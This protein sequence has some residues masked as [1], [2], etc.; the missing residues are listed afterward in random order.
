MSRYADQQQVTNVKTGKVERV[1]VNLE[2]VYPNE[3]DPYE[4]MSFE[5]L[6]ANSRGWLSR[7]WAAESRQRVA[8][9][10]QHSTL[11]KEE[12]RAIKAM[13]QHVEVVDISQSQQDTQPGTDTQDSLGTTLENTISI[14]IDREGR[15]GRPRKTKLREVKGETQTSMC[16]DSVFCIS[17]LICYSQNQSRVAHWAK[18]EKEE[19]G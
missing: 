12:S 19:F 2:A 6:R 8:E 18:A 13:G 15:S 9:K 5:E 3:N 17:G 10:H 1:F 11:E 4:E 16:R 7:D 14:D